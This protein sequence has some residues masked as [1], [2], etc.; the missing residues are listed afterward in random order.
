MVKKI[1]KYELEVTDEQIIKMPEGAKILCVQVQREIP[2]LW[3]IVDTEKK[4]KP[5]K[6]KIVTRGTGHPLSYGINHTEYIGTFQLLDGSFVG[7]VFEILED[8]IKITVT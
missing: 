5:E 2:C 1:Y 4:D 6:R 3:A 8:K 7:H